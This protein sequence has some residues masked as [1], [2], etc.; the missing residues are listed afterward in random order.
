V[1]GDG[2]PVAPSLPAHGIFWL[3][4]KTR[5]EH[6]KMIRKHFRMR[7]LV[8]GLAFAAIAVPAA[9][10][11]TYI[12]R[13]STPVSGPTSS[14]QVRSENSLRASVLT[15]LQVEG[16]RLQA[17]ADAYRQPGLVTSER[18]YG[19]PGPDPSYA[20][21]VVSST[22]RGF[23]WKDAGV[24]ASTAF[25]IALLLLTAVAMGRRRRGGFDQPGLT[26]A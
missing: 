20:P 4:Q 24:G 9:Q 19:A 26:S 23:D 17:I 2:H 1:G 13:G 25:G 16:L 8:L 12:E 5:K 6:T 3:P 18:S 21:V 14:A 15:P 11:S 10:A 22:S 7:R